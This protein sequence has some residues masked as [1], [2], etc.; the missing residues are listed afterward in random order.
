MECSWG[1]G[2]SGSAQ[3]VPVDGGG[4]RVHAEWSYTGAHR[5]RDKVM[6]S[7][8]QRFPLRRIIAR[9]WVKGLDRYAHSGLA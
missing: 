7:L 6:L 8:I 4:S 2:G 5:R 1:G 9:G 3:I